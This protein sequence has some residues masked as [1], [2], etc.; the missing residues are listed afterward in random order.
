MIPA[1]PGW[2]AIYESSR[3]DAAGRL[4]ERRMTVVGWDGQGDALV[5]DEKTGKL[6]LAADSGR[7]TEVKR[8]GFTDVLP[9][10]GWMAEFREGDALVSYPIIA[11]RVSVDGGYRG[12]VKDGHTRGKVTGWATCLAV[13]VRK[14]GRGVPS[15]AESSG[16]HRHRTWP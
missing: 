13:G 15:G 7:L 12:A 5:V 3:A 6:R 14:P 16:V 4:I 2:V 1:P 10:G 9:G 11:W 8:V